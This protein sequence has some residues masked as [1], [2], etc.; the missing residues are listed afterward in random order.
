MPA[1]IHQR[2][3]DEQEVPPVVVAA[4]YDEPIDITLQMHQ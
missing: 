3:E 1:T 4:S 2:E